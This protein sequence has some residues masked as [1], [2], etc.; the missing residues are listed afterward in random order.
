MRTV[1]EL[2]AE[3][4]KFPDD[5]MCF[6]YE[7]EVCGLVIEPA[8]RTKKIIQGVIWCGEGRTRKERE[9]FVPKELRG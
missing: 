4:D 1:K 8:K 2:K 6:A 3:L 9:T 5:A 7:G